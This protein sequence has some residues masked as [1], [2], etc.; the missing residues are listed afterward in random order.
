MDD[1]TFWQSTATRLARRLNLGRWLETALPVWAA[2]SVVAACALLIVRNRGDVDPAWFGLGVVAAGVIGG[3][4]VFVFGTRRDLASTDDALVWL[5]H[6]MGL[7]N[8]LTAAAAGI[9][10][11][12]TPR[13]DALELL[14]WRPSRLL[15][16]PLFSALLLV[17]AG[18]IP[19][20]VDRGPIP[21]PVSPPVAWTEMERWLEEVQQT[22]LV[23]EQAIEAWHERVES[24]ESQPKEEWFSHSSL[25]ASDSLREELASELRA[26]EKGLSDAEASLSKMIEL[27]EN[28]SPE[29]RRLSQKRLGES[30]EDLELASLP[31]S[32]KMKR[33]L[34]TLAR[35][36]NVKRMTKEQ[37]EQLRERL[38]ERRYANLPRP[39]DDAYAFLTPGG[40]DT[41]GSSGEP[42][43]GGVNRG[44]GSA[45]ID[46]TGER[47]E[48][49]TTRIEDVM[50]HEPLGAEFGETVSVG[51]GEHDVD[52]SEFRV[53]GVAGATTARGEGG[54][55]VWSQTLT[56]EERRV[57]E[58]YFK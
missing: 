55:L 15:P 18:W 28:A 58:K 4:A 3:L 51:L 24:L 13:R 19:V 22:E 27:D 5:E 10:E 14:A 42:G 49:E 46:L 54:E 56:P 40:S 30:L 44:P 39:G 45:P 47:T 35:E 57:L 48:L 52:T 8:R 32:R 33:Q 16:A 6:R 20:T 2:V 41:Q 34:M 53:G 12:P 37:L 11:W 25:E 50:G 38:R 17:T 9:G 36:R 21:P 29:K 7:N 1:S 43:R 26:L 31:L 23:E